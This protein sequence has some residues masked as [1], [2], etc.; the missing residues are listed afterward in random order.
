[1]TVL[2]FWHKA[3]LQPPRVRGYLA[4]PDPQFEAQAKDGSEQEFVETQ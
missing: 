2:R 3:G 4:S 1:M